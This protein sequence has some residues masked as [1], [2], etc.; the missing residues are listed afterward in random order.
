[1]SRVL[2]QGAS[3]E[4]CGPGSRHSRLRQPGDRHAI[5]RVSR[6]AFFKRTPAPPPFSSMNSTPAANQRGASQ[7][8]VARKRDLLSVDPEGLNPT[9]LKT[10]CKHHRFSLTATLYFFRVPRF[11]FL[12]RTPGPPPFS[13]MNS[14]PAP[15]R[16]RCNASTVLSFNSAPRSNL[17]TVS[18]ET[19][20][21]AASSRT[22]NPSAARAIRHWTGNKIIILI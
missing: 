14:T 9:N 22:P 12:R 8:A 4:A 20:A 21:A 3:E 13:S 19:L 1:M 5:F 6:F 11:A 10:S 7:G 17:A 16:V 18:I 15:S 2:V